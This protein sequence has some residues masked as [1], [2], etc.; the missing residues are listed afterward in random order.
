MGAYRKSLRPTDTNALVAFLR[1]S[2]PANQAIARNA[3]QGV[4]PSMIRSKAEV[5]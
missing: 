4:A 2:H 1:T 3:S 5:L